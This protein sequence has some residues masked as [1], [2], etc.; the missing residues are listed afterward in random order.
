MKT[1][2]RSRNEIIKVHPCFSG[3]AHSRFG[4]IHLPVAPLCNIHCKYCLRKYD[5]P[6]ESR[7]GI[8]SRVL[9]VQEAIERVRSIV[10]RNERL[11]VIAVAG[12]GEP[13]ANK[14]TFEVL[15]A[16]KKEFP[17][18]ILC[19]STNGL[20]LYERLDDLIKAGVKS[21]TITINAVIPEVAERIYSWVS[22][23]G[24][25]LTGKTAV[26]CLLCNQWKG[27][28]EAVEAGI[29]VKI[30]SVLIPGINDEEIPMIAWLAGR[31]GAVIHN[32]IPLIPQAE[33]RTLKRPTYEM[34]QEVREKSRIYL[35]Q[36]T[37]CR[38]CRADACG[39]LS[40]DMDMELETLMSK[41]GEEYCEM[42]L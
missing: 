40:E 6:N 17:E 23:R 3:D 27:L 42:V 37:H 29:I 31:R 25:T 7:P 1:F 15:R 36:M 41:I 19:V 34:L 4:R 13:L 39:N 2:F 28:R 22:Y 20:L 21:I 9:T 33:F 14:T 32:I 11:R 10:T 35:P 26:E 30:N 12:P 16:V 24:E 8:S 38:Q 18:I 5:C